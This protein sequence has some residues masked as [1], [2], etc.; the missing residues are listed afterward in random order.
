ME[1]YTAISYKVSNLVTNAYSTSFGL[2]IR[3]FHPSLRS[4]I[5][6]VYGL[7]RIADE[8]VDT[9][10]GADQRELLDTLED[11]TIRALQSGYSTNPIVHAFVQTART[12]QIT[13]DILAPFFESMR[14]D[15]TPKTFDQHTYEKYIYGS[16]EVVGLM[17]LKIFT[18]SQKQ[19]DTL[20]DA[21]KKLGSAYQ[22]VNFLRDIA[23]DADEL[24]RWYFP[25]SSK[26]TFDET[27]KQAIIIDIEED[28]LAGSQGITALPISSQ[29]AVRLSYNY[30]LQLLKKI[31]RTPASDLLQRRVRINDPQKIVLLVRTVLNVRQTIHST[32]VR[33]H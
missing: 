30:Y 28:F 26:E 6:A 13:N 4:H 5:Y 17:C 15:L 2:S 33:D 14:M 11:E 9:Y 16:A 18:T 21:A 25:N 8:I 22:K 32:S 1:Q 29:K 24:G 3:L 12:Y 7:V 19:Y 27:I 23:A 31:K 20:K 10:V